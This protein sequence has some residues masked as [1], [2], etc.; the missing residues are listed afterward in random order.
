MITT[1]EAHE[2]LQFSRGP[3]FLTWRM[4]TLTLGIRY[5]FF[6]YG[7]KDERNWVYQTSVLWDANDI[8]EF[9]QCLKD[10]KSAKILE[11]SLLEHL[12]SNKNKT[13]RWAKVVEIR[14]YEM[15]SVK[16]PVYITD[17]GEAVGFTPEGAKRK[18]KMIYRAPTS[19]M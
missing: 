17:A 11:I 10:N 3:G 19:P 4:A 18:M 6:N 13:W 16:H 5:V 14:S 1:H 12:G 9:C 7:L 2:V 15:D 8:M